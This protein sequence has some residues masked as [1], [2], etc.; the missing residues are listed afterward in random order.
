[1]VFALGVDRMPERDAASWSD[2]TITVA[3]FAVMRM[4]EE[5]AAAAAGVDPECQEIAAPEKGCAA[6]AALLDGAERIVAYNGRRFHLRLLRNLFDD[7]RVAGWEAKLTD[8]FEQI[9]ETTHSWVKLDELLEA[10]GLI[11]RESGSS[12]GSLVSLHRQ[13][14]VVILL[15]RLLRLARDSPVVVPIKTF[16]KRARTDRK[17]T[18]HVVGWTEV[19][20]QLKSQPVGKRLK[21]IV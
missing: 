8:P 15:C 1:V 17:W 14:D 18:N 19:R 9:R 7:A 13:R 21:K 2:T 6:I 5:A 4:G 16:G 11:K 12:G 20:L 10:N 3:A